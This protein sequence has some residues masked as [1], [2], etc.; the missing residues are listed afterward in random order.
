MNSVTKYLV[1]ITEL[2]FIQ[3]EIADQDFGLKGANNTTANNNNIIKGD[4][5]VERIERI[6]NIEKL[7]EVDFEWVS[8]AELVWKS[9][10]WV[11]VMHTIVQE[12]VVTL[13]GREMEGFTVCFLFCFLFCFVFVFIFFLFL[14]F[15]VCVFIYLFIYLFICDV[16][17]FVLFDFIFFLLIFFKIE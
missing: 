2:L 5:I 3:P 16:L 11:K 6:K 17:F 4:G 14:F 12:S 1:A 7:D 13:V 9:S 10:K 15:F 8:R